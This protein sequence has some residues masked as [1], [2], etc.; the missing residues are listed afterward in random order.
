MH[1]VFF[2][3]VSAE[4]Q[5]QLCL[6]RVIKEQIRPTV[7]ELNRVGQIVHYFGWSNVQG[8]QQIVRRKKWVPGVAGSDQVGQARTCL[9]NHA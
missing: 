6:L 2:C 5:R 7:N 3:V 4:T 8:L 9:K 1:A